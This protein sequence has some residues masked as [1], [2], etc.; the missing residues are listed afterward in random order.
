MQNGQSHLNSLIAAL[1]SSSVKF[2]SATALLD[3]CAGMI[4]D[5]G[6]AA[7]GSLSESRIHTKSFNV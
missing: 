7:L 3:G 2:S 6:G 1:L 4:A 5:F